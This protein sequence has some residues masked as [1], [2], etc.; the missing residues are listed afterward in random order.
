M[1][2]AVERGGGAPSGAGYGE[3]TEMRSWAQWGSEDENRKD[4]AG[5]LGSGMLLEEDGAVHTHT[6]QQETPEQPDE[7]KTRPGDV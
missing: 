6:A 7:R 2:G 1:R 4:N 3:W 5:E